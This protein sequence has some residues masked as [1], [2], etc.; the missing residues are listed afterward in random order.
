MT[1]IG[2]QWDPEG[3]LGI[4]Q[5]FSGITCVGYAHSKNRRCQNPISAANRETATERLDQMSKM[6]IS[7]P[8]I[9]DHLKPLGRLLL[10]KLSQHQDQ[11]LNVVEN[12]CKQIERMQMQ[13]AA[14]QQLV[15]KWEEE[16]ENDPKKIQRCIGRLEEA[17]RCSDI[18]EFQESIV[19]LNAFQQRQIRT[20]AQLAA[21]TASYGEL[22]AEVKSLHAQLAASG[23]HLAGTSVTIPSLVATA[24]SSQT[25]STADTDASSTGETPLLP[26]KQSVS[27]DIHQGTDGRCVDCS[28]RIRSEPKEQSKI[29]ADVSLEL[30]PQIVGE[31]R[32]QRSPDWVSQSLNSQVTSLTGV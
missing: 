16:F 21:L 13:R 18:A 2:R 23:E 20:Q 31:G 25:P 22:N 1:T 19:L 10:C 4:G 3:S 14:E 26:S 9:S 12:W 8:Q 7:S 24:S 6:D 5:V 11:I 28:R 29:S 32:S 17:A 27:D 30:Y 15:A